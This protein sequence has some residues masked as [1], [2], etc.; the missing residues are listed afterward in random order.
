MSDDEYNSVSL[1]KNVEMITSFV[2]FELN[3]KRLINRIN[4]VLEKEA[5]NEQNYNTSMELL[6]KIENY[7]NQLSESISAVLDFPGISVPALLKMCGTKIVDDSESPIESVFNYMVLV[8]ELLGEKLFVFVNMN[9]FFRQ[10]DLQL[11]I[12]SAVGHEFYV[13]MIDGKEN[14]KLDMVKTTIVDKDLCVF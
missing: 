14:G 2:P 6:A 1:D 10:D 9:T 5:L 12:D 8:R 4:G 13:L 11:F 3:E 7:V